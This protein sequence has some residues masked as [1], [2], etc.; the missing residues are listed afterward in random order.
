MT[1][2]LSAKVLR[3]LVGTLLLILGSAFLVVV[4]FEVAIRFIVEN[5]L[6]TVDFFVGRLF[7]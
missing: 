1:E 3:S 5:V 7:S 2:P 6:K 4:L